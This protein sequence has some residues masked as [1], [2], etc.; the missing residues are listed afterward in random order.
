[1]IVV[2]KLVTGEEVIAE[3]LRTIAGVLDNVYSRPRV[4]HMIQTREGMQ[5]AL[6]P[7][8]VTCPDSDVPIEYEK[9]VTMI[10]APAEVERAYQQNVSGLEIAQSL[11]G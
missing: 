8:L 11:V 9:I 2:M 6:A 5:A 7:L 10:E 1:M 3:R 4:V